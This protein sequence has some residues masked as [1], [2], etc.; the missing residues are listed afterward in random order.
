MIEFSSQTGGRYTYVDDIIN[1]QELALAFSAFFA[2]CDN[3]IIGG[4]Q[5]SGN[6]ISSGYVY[7]NGKIRYFPGKSDI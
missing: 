5:V 6:Q 1:L 4:C 7:I 2:D 3:F